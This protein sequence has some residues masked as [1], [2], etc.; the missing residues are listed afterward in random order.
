[1]AFAPDGQTLALIDSGTN[2]FLWNLSTRQT[3]TLASHT[4]TIMGIAYNHQGRWLA[5]ASWDDSIIVWDTVEHQ[6]VHRLTGHAGNV[7]TVVFG[8][9]GSTLFSGSA[10]KKIIAWNPGVRQALGQTLHD[11]ATVTSLTF[12]DN[13]TL[14]SGGCGKLAGA[15]CQ[16]GEVRMWNTTNGQFTALAGH[17]GLINN[18]AISSDGKWLAT[19]SDD[20]DIIVWD[21]A[22]R[23]PVGAPLTGHTGTVASAAFSPDGKWLAS[24]DTQNTTIVWDLATHQPITTVTSPNWVLGVAFSPDGQWV[25]SGGCA[26]DDPY[27]CIKGRIGLWSVQARRPITPLL[28][29][30]DWVIA[31]AFSPNSQLLAS[32]SADGTI[33]LWDMQSRHARGAPLKGH[34]GRITEIAFSPDGK[35]LASASDDRTVMLWDI[36]SRHP[37]GP[38]AGHTSWFRDVAFSPD[39][40]TLAS[41]S[42]DG[43]IIIWDANFEAWRARACR[44]ANRNLTLAEWHEFIDD[45][46]YQA[47]CPQFPVGDVR[48]TP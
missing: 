16:Q 3:I 6:P 39:G 15:V 9:D 17:T 8:A 23:Q 46:D 41:A 11:A 29:H 19:V 27:Y 42:D 20:K 35:R 38:L 36:A 40:L 26:N 7:K 10:D 25:A 44:R 24:G 28:G 47:T 2:L 14:V 32:A 22:L 33:I 45:R 37:I 1:M 12:A 21:V 13:Q 30:T 31:I 5:S 18:V 34:S 43:T 48:P 4:E